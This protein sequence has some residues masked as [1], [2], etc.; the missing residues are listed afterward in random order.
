[1]IYLCAPVDVLAQRLEATPKATQRPTLTGKPISE[2]VSDILAER[3]A[4]YREAAH[5]VVDGAQDPESVVAEIQ[6]VLLL[7]RAS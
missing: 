5:Y 4:L 3:D 7:A 2:E 1:M 6:T